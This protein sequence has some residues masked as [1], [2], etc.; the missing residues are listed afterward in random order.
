[1]FLLL[2]QNESVTDLILAASGCQVVHPRRRS[3]RCRTET[4]DTYQMPTHSLSSQPAAVAMESGSR[5]DR[6]CDAVTRVLARVCLTLFWKVYF[7]T[8]YL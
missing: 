5:E 7:H 8:P 1:M 4:N 3:G 6:L 2:R